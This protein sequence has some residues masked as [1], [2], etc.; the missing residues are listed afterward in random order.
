MNPAQRHEAT[1]R[2][3]VEQAG[4]ELAV[5]LRQAG[6][7]RITTKALDTVA[8]VTVDA[9]G[10]TAGFP[11]TQRVSRTP[12]D[13]VDDL[14]DWTAAQKRRQTHTPMPHQPRPFT[15]D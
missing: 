10:F 6:S 8:H 3:L 1:L 4:F 15:R 13:L 12:T 14:E 2:T 5:D 11:A 9:R 7:F